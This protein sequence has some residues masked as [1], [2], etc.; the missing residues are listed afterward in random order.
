M[1]RPA[2]RRQGRERERGTRHV[3]DTERSPM[4]LSNAERQRRY[5][6]KLKAQ[7]DQLR[8][9][10]PPPVLGAWSDWIDRYAQ[11]DRFNQNQLNAEGQLATILYVLSALLRQGEV[12][13][14]AANEDEPSIGFTVTADMPK[15]V[16]DE[17]D[18]GRMLR[19]AAF[20]G[21]TPAGVRLWDAGEPVKLQVTIA[22]RFDK[23]KL[24][25][26]QRRVN[27]EAASSPL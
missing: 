4:G 14:L 2:N 5:R 25:A 16:T 1:G 3:T 9:L 8:C 22:A 21:W 24:K 6:E 23:R 20:Y 15:R 27:A 12:S 7:R 11:P 19:S 10:L 26:M 18:I 17:N 13:S